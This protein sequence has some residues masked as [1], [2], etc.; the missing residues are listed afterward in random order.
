M[1]LEPIFIRQCAEL[2]SDKERDAWFRNHAAEAQKAGCT[3]CRF[4]IHPDNINRV[5]VEGWTTRPRR[6][7]PQRWNVTARD[8]A[9]SAAA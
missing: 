1:E 3:Y 6:T 4:T 5:M 2:K 8:P 9:P 7:L